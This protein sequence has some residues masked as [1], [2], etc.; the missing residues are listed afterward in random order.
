MPTEDHDSWLGGL[1][2]D[3][4]QIRDKVQG[5][6]SDVET[7]V[8]QGI[9]SVVQGATQVYKDAENVVT[10]TVQKV[11]NA[12]GQV[13][14]AVKKGVDAAKMKALG[15]Q[16]GKPVPRPM[17]ADCKPE[18]GYVPGPKNHL[19]CATHG[20]VVDTD[21]GNIIAESV[22]AYLKQGVAA[23]IDKAKSALNAD[24][25]GS[26]LA[27]DI[28]KAAGK[29]SATPDNPF[30][31]P[32]AQ[33]ELDKLLRQLPL[34][35]VRQLVGNEAGDAFV[36]YLRA[37]Q[38]VGDTLKAAADSAA[39]VNQLTF[40][41]TVA[42]AVVVLTPLTAGAAA[43]LAGEVV[44]AQLVNAIQT[45]GAKILIGAGVQLEKAIDANAVAVA[46]TD[47]I[48]R[49]STQFSAS[50]VQ[51]IFGEAAKSLSKVITVAANTDRFAVGKNY[52]DQLESE[53]DQSKKL[54]NPVIAAASLEQLLGLYN[55]L[56]SSSIASYTDSVSKQLS[57]F[58]DQM[59]DVIVARAKAAL[60]QHASNDTIVEMDAYGRIRYARVKMKLPSDPIF[61][62]GGGTTYTFVA[63]VSPE[64]EAMAKKMGAER[65]DPNKI[66]GHI[67]DPGPDPAP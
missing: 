26:P 1:G 42:M 16:S 27:D 58:M 53:V 13:V 50:D 40:E 64:L 5:V 10:Q 65:I 19:L 49:F 34:E 32:A 44:Q 41:I 14:D 6:V 28:S 9:D 51:R 21:T 37:V 67:P 57:N 48:T 62:S 36:R 63:W 4:D 43:A 46:A 60:N 23:V 59:A 12:G 30:N 15:D 33:V 29:P 66:V 11:E 61:T 45:N 55:S 17:E 20:H 18:H 7:K 3:I 52:L 35:P 54:L 38:K 24:P 39:K 31:I 47:T 22:A 25:G 56:K 8:E 2:I